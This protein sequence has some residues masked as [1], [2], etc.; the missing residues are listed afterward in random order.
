MPRTQWPECRGGLHAFAAGLMS[1]APLVRAAVVGV[2][3]RLEATP[4][5][6]PLVA[7]LC[8]LH[9]AAYHRCL[10]AAA[11]AAAAAQ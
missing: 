5:T 3:S 8:Y 11:R 4:A 9:A 10:Q 6:R 2:L 1:P 7:G